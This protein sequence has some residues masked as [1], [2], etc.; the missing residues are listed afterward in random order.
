LG[1][2]RTWVTQSSEYWVDGEYLLGESDLDYQDDEE[3]E[4]DEDDD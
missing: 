2:E 1:G 4:D 3:Y